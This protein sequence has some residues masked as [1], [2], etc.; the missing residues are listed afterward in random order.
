[1]WTEHQLAQLRVRNGFRMR[2][3]EI[4]RLEALTDGAFALALTFLVIAQ[5]QVPQTVDELLEA[6]KLVPAFALSFIVLILFWSAHVRWSRRYGMEDAGAAALSCLLIFIVLVIVY[7][8][9]MVFGA[10]LG[11]LSDGALPGALAFHSD[12]QL[13]QLF[14]IYGAGFVVLELSLVGLYGLALRRA[15]ALGL[16]A[17]ERFDTRSDI[18]V[19]LISLTVAVLATALAVLLPASMAALSGYSYWLIPIGIAV[20]RRRGRPQRKRLLAETAA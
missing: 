12:Q 15:D 14:I 9:K 20:Y 6:L 10:L 2:G 13:R 4:T 3:G 11:Y 5:Q 1:M 18:V 19:R 8:L 7:P 17:L 16:N